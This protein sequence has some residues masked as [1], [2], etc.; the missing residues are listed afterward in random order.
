MEQSAILTLAQARAGVALEHERN[1][2]V[3]AANEQLKQ[4]ADAFQEQGR[5]LASVHGL[6]GEARYRF[7]PS[8]EGVR[9][10]A[11]WEEEDERADG[12]G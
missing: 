4:I 1:E 2:I 6:P 9:L 10:V 12:N 3:Q 8:D 5:I 7:E 11:V